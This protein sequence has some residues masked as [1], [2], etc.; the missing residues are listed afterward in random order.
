MMDNKSGEDDMCE[1]RWSAVHFYSITQRCNA[2]PSIKQHRETSQHSTPAAIN[3]LLFHTL[4]CN[5][6]THR[7]RFTVLCRL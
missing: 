5:A 4:I 3:Q 7:N 6:T 1:V 2:A